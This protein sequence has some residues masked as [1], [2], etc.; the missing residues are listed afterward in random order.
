MDLFAAADAVVFDVEGV[1]LDTEAL[2][3]EVQERLLLRR[4][5]AYDRAAIKPLLTGRSA[6]DAVAVL[7][8]V[9]GLP[10]DPADL[11]RERHALM[12]DRLAGGVTLVPGFAELVRALAG[13]R[14]MALATAMDP[15]LFA[16]AD[17]STGLS[18][19]VGGPVVTLR[20]VVP[21]VGRSDGLSPGL[22]PGPA[23]RPLR[24]KPWPDLFQEAC[25]LLGV[26]PER[27]LVVED[28]PNGVAA[29][30]RAGARCVAVA[31]THPAALLAD[32][33][34]VCGSVADLVPVVSGLAERGAPYVCP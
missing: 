25:R 12:L 20:E 16:L 21:A 5:I 8:A 19:L 32:A 2:W 26:P 14:P 31:T 11:L 29:A 22:A 13:R 18:A 10:D 17:R 28:A 15:K 1:A 6:A 33:D 7:A 34:A 23:R 24:G 27:C 30:H 3:D 9:C 4:G